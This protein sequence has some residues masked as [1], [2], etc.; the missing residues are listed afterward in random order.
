MTNMKNNLTCLLLISFSTAAAITNTK[1]LK[2][3]DD[4]YGEK[5]TYT[6]S[7]GELECINSAVIMHTSIGTYNVNGKAE[8]RY[9]DK[10]RSAREITKPHP[11]INHPSAK[12]PP[13]SGLIQRG[14]ELCK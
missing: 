3:T 1:T 9:K 7:E 11:T 5:W 13:P 10:Y 12:M 8:T 6:V 4:E 2:V 14:L